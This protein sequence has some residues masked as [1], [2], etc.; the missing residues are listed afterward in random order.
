MGALT[1][2]GVNVRLGV[3]AILLLLVFCSSAPQDIV[4]LE[5]KKIFNS[6]VV[7]NNNFELLSKYLSLIHI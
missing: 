2:K 1:T 3:L 7:L 5:D 6:M 4:Q